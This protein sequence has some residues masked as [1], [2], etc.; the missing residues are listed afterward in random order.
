MSG[1]RQ[2][3]R[4]GEMNAKAIQ[5]SAADWLMERQEAASWT[6]ERQAALDAWLGA[7]VAHRVAYIRLDTAW[8]RTDRLAAMRKPAAAEATLQR[9]RGGALFLKTAAILI[10]AGA[11]GAAVANY[12][13]TPREQ[14]FATG[15]GGHRVVTLAGGSQ[16]E[17]NTDTVVRTVVNATQRTV[18]LDRGEAYFQ[19]RHDPKHPFILVVGDQRIVDLGTKFLARREIGRL[20]V[21]VIQGRVRFDTAAGGEKMRSALL[22]PGS[23]AIAAAGLVSVTQKSSQTLT[24]LLGWRRGVLVFDHTTLAAAAV[25]FNRYN[26][27]K[28]IVADGAVSRLTIDGTFPTKDTDAFIDVAQEVFGLRVEN[29]SDETVISR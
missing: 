5:I 25:E 4:D 19:V 11:L 10:V 14:V 27:K 28:I 12:I 29:R 8:S 13:L 2:D 1:A 7:S 18:W 6:Q 23:V 16:I 24:N 9:Q 17:L 15:T 22:A 20:E 3:N 26:S 21:D